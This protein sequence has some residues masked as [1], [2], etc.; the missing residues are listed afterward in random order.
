MRRQSWL[1]TTRK[2][3]WADRVIALRD[4]DLAAVRGHLLQER[5]HRGLSATY[6][7]AAGMN[8]FIGKPFNPEQ[9]IST[10]LHWLTHS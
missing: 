2:R 9:L 3:C 6:A 10:L 8:D 1:P 5:V 4:F 7:L